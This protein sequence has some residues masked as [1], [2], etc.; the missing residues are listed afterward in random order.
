M[1]PRV[2]VRC[3]KDVWPWENSRTNHGESGNEDKRHANHVDCNIDRVMVV[4]TI[5]GGEKT[6]RQPDCYLLSHGL[7]C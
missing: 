2:L 5:L 6:E 1:W 7:S 4:S 3:K